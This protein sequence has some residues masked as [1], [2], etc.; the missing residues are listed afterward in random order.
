MSDIL[1]DLRKLQRLNGDT[2]S[3]AEVLG[4]VGQAADEIERL[5]VALQEVVACSS[6]CPECTVTARAALEYGKVEQ[7]SK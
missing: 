6:T 3:S 5:R 4:M 7:G 2:Y 1:A